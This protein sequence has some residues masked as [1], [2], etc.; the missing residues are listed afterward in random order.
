IRN[1]AVTKVQE[2]VDRNPGKKVVMF[3]PA[4][5]YF[6]HKDRFST[7]YPPAISVKK[8]IPDDPEDEEADGQVMV[9]FQ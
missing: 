3:F 6:S 7:P 5:R 1:Q 9:R 8:S 4:D 2:L